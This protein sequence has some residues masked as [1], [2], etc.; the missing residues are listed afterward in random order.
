[1]RMGFVIARG[2]IAAVNI[3]VA[4]ACTLSSASPYFGSVDPPEGQQLRYISGSEPESLDPPQSS[5]QPEARIQV[6]FFD[7][8]T[9]YHPRTS[10]PI[11]SSQSSR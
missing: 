2:L 9:D 8:L 5:G 4:G 10:Q 6:A 3:S 7:G 1:M 11:P